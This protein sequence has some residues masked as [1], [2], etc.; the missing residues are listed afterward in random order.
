MSLCGR[1]QSEERTL[2][3]LR[4]WASTHLWN[5]WYLVSKGEN[6][7]GWK[8]KL[9]FGSTVLHSL[10]SLNATRDT[11]GCHCSYGDMVLA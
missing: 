10:P 1:S 11:A 4:D 2:Q 5:P 6:R 9:S 8:K 3:K 7:R